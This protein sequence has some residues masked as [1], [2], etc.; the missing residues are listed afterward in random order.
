MKLLIKGKKLV[1]RA[2]KLA[3]AVAGC[4]S[5][6][7]A[8]STWNRADLCNDG[9]APPEI[10]RRITF[11]TGFTCLDGCPISGGRLII[12]RGYCYF[13][14]SGPGEVQCQ[15]PRD[16][17]AEYP[18]PYFGATVVTW[19]ELVCKPLASTCL[20]QSCLPVEPGCCTLPYQWLACDT[21]NPVVCNLPKKFRVRRIAQ[22]R[23]RSWQVD[24]FNTC[25]GHVC[26]EVTLEI[27]GYAD[28][29]CQETGAE[30]S[31][32]CT[33]V[34][35][36]VRVTG[37][38]NST[39]SGL[40]INGTHP[41]GVNVGSLFTGFAS[42]SAPSDATSFGI[43]LDVIS[44]LHAPISGYPFCGGSHGFVDDP[45]GCFT[46]NHVC[47]DGI[48]SVFTQSANCANGTFS[49]T[50]YR[51]CFLWDQTYQSAGN[52]LPP[53]QP[54]EAWNDVGVDRI[55]LSGLVGCENAPAWDGGPVGE[56]RPY[57]YP[58]TAQT[59]AEMLEGMA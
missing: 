4:I 47:P 38:L 7:C 33:N 11:P 20:D 48:R 52:Y 6:C 19:A 45:P 23:W 21:N 15:G 1:V 51:D 41:F 13:V 42:P 30:T 9:D 44:R 53:C 43:P 57:P 17:P 24:N 50:V 5:Q 26:E 59:T 8:P 3:L 56:E 27:D 39:G 40:D 29:A 35:G 28:Y 55:T 37:W 34:S 14:V 10:P 18:A 31:P 16:K 32:L 25:A 54:I 49:N 12:Y 2:R 36:F 22:W 58:I 46:Q